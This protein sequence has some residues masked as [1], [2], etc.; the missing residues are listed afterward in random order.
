MNNLMLGAKRLTKEK[1]EMT[2]VNGNGG[3]R[4]NLEA[5]KAYYEALNT[6][7]AGK[8][9]KAQE[10]KP[11]INFT[12]TEKVEASALDATAAQIW[13]VQLSKVD[14]SDAATQKRIEQYFNTP[15]MEK[16][17][18]LQG[19]EPEDNFAAYAMANVKGV[20]HDKL[21]KYMDKPLGEET[22]SGVTEF[23]DALV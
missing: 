23:L 13:G 18:E 4:T 17:D 5:L 15:F 7:R 2:K 12:G 8:E 1:T 20:D 11:V 3:D 16:L 9:E 14:K 22:A 19:I 21:A 6:K 10:A